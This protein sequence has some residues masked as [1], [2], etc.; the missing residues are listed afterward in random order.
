M[1]WKHGNGE[2]TEEEVVVK[3]FLRRLPKVSRAY[4][5]FKRMIKL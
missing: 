2:N 3:R 4:H 1:K 5:R